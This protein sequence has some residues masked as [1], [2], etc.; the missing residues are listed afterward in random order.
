[1]RVVL[2]GR[3]RSAEAATVAKESVH[4]RGRQSGKRISEAMEAHA[5]AVAAVRDAR[6]P[7]RAVG[8]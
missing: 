6:P 1:L 3:L 4:K 8:S 2:L 5:H 7:L